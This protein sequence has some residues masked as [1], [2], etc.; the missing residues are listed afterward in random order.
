MGY[1]VQ[2]LPK[3]SLPIQHPLSPQSS[4]TYYLCQTREKM[5]TFSEAIPPHQKRGTVHYCSYGIERCKVHDGQV[6]FGIYMQTGLTDTDRTEIDL[7][8]H[9]AYA[10]EMTD[11][12]LQSIR[13]CSLIDESSAMEEAKSVMFPRAQ[14]TLRGKNIESDYTMND[15]DQRYVSNNCSGRLCW[16]IKP[17]SRLHFTADL[18]HPNIPTVFFH[19]TKVICPFHKDQWKVLGAFR[20]NLGDQA[21]NDS[22]RTQLRVS[23]LE[24]RVRSAIWRMDGT[25]AEHIL[26]EYFF[27]GVTRVLKSTCGS[28][29]RLYLMTPNL[30]DS[31][32]LR[33][34]IEF[35]DGDDCS[36]QD[37][38]DQSRP[39]PQLPQL[40]S[41]GAG[42]P[43]GTT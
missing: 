11:D 33:N 25:M 36:I 13:L 16:S 14:Q 37:T 18:E 7:D 3:W 5:N 31:E 28:G 32:L 41:D 30:N 39:S 22:I 34:Q 24:P 2:H 42:G 4:Q 23:S 26:E 38:A 6:R 10:E 35:C 21:V 8:Y 29:H 43:S 20:S 1:K 40:Q 19:T 12:A 17:R 15:A 9:T 27:V